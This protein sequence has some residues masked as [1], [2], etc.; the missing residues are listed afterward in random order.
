MKEDRPMAAD[1]EALLAEERK[2]RRLSRA[3]DLAAAPR[4]LLA[5]GPALGLIGLLATRSPGRNALA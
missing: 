5:Q 2:L 1:K 3:M 4:L